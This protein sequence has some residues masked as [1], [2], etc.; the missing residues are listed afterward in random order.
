[1][2]EQKNTYFDEYENLS[3]HP[4]NILLFLLL[5]GVTALFL[6]LSAAFIYTRVQADLPPVQLP[7]IFILNTL[8]LIGSSWTLI[9]AK[10]LTKK[11][12]RMIIKTT[13][14]TPLSFL[15]SFWDCKLSVGISFFKVIIF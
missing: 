3:F 15:L 6:S 5:F 2:E 1:M 7:W 10:K 11:T 12:K 13:S 8:V 9:Q 4:Y 14:F